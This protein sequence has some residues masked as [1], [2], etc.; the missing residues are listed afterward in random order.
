MGLGWAFSSLTELT[1]PKPV[2]MSWLYIRREEN[3]PFPAACMAAHHLPAAWMGKRDGKNSGYHL[4]ARC[5]LHHS[6]FLFPI[7]WDGLQ[8]P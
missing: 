7:P 1:A 2:V 3:I 8:R 6:T 5:H 4:T